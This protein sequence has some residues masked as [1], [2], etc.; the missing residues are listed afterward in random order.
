MCGRKR[1]A[2]RR[3]TASSDADEPLTG[4]RHLCR[5]VLDLGVLGSVLNCLEASHRYPEV[6]LACCQLTLGLIA[7]RL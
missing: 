4:R 5:R 1:S 7:L 2:D 3:G 6:L